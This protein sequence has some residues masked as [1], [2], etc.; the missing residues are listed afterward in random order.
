MPAKRVSIREIGSLMTMGGKGGRI[1]SDTDCYPWQFSC[2]TAHVTPQIER[3][4]TVLS[5]S[6]STSDALSDSDDDD[7]GTVGVCS[8]AFRG[9]R[10]VNIEVLKNS[11]EGIAGCKH[12]MKKDSF[13]AV[14][15][16]VQYCGRNGHDVRALFT[17]WKRTQE[18]VSVPTI[19]FHET[20]YG[21]GTDIVIHCNRCSTLGEKYRRGY[22]E[23]RV[24]V[25]GKKN[26]T[27]K[28]TKSNLCHYDI[29]VR[30]VIALQL[31]GLGGEHAAVMAAFLDLPEPH[32]WRRQFKVVEKLLSPM[33]EEIKQNCQEDAAEKEVQLTLNA[34]EN[35]VEQT[36]LQ[37]DL[38]L[39][40]VRASF[41]MGWQVRSSGGKYGSTSGHAF[42]IGALSKKIL[43]SVIYTKRCAICSGHESRTG[44]LEGVKAHTCVKNFEGSSKSMEAAALIQMIIRMPEEKGISVCCIISDD[45][46]CGR[47]RARN[48]N[49]GGQLPA[50][51]EEPT[52]LAD[53]SHRKRVFA[54]AVYN[55]ANAPMKTSAVT[56]GLAGH[57]KNCYGACVKRNRHRSAEDLSDH[58]HNILEHICGNHTNCDESWCYDKKAEKLGKQFYPPKDHRIDR[59]DEKTY[60]QL[61]SIFDQYANVS[62]MAQCNHPF[63]TQT[64]EALNNAIANVSPKTVCYSGTISLSCRIN[65]IIGIH[66]MG[67]APYLSSLFGTIG[68][69]M[70]PIMETFLLE[71]SERKEY[72][73]KYINKV[74]VKSRRSKKQRRTWQQVYQERTDTSYGPGIALI[75]T[76]P[77]KKRRI[78]TSNDETGKTCKCGSTSHRRTTH[79]DC[80]LRK[81]K[82]TAAAS[83]VALKTPVEDTPRFT[84]A[85]GTPVVETDEPMRPTAASYFGTGYETET[86]HEEDENDIERTRNVQELANNLSLCR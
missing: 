77:Q 67:H 19:T 46:S 4:G 71:K 50:N 79:R 47:A 85:I 10:L 2:C 69:A 51:I 65:L 49:N 83:T 53:P 59:K 44:T 21:L 58:V 3:D 80:P 1:R 22:K 23:H 57:L 72:K 8:P 37:Q 43:D 45:D 13:D 30:Y 28:M 6:S 42:L 35:V 68:V 34:T 70:T 5:S 11:M 29:N 24:A 60:L 12:C 31:L 78:D 56:K 55:L 54:R 62:M 48:M 25:D 82:G 20:T 14:E 40:R 66:N 7:D 81:G 76:D 38:P 63:D 17:N 18:E 41:D 61:K 39:Y 27:A 26:N 36:L 86:S 73:Q 84:T 74:E 32:K 75:T 9:N 16:F 33:M 64:N 52:F 15:D